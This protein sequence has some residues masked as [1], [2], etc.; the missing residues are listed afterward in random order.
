MNFQQLKYAVE[1]EKTESISK[2]A[3]KL[4]MGQPNLS[5]SIKELESEIGITLFT[6]SPK[7][8]SATVE[9]KEFLRYA[10]SIV[11]QVEE[12]QNTYV[13]QEKKWKSFTVAS[14]RATYVSL[15]FTNFVNRMIGTKD[16]HVQYRET[17]A[18][19]LINLV[20][21]GEANVGILRYNVM[22]EEYYLEQLMENNL[23]YEELMTFQM[24]VMVDKAHPLSAREKLNY[25]ELDNY[26]EIRHGDYYQLQNLDEFDFHKSL[27]NI[28]YVYDRASQFDIL[29]CVKGSYMFVSPMPQRFLI[30]SGFQCIAC[31][32]A[33]VHR[34]VLIFQREKKPSAYMPVFKE[35][36]KAVIHE[37][38]EEEPY[39]RS[40]DSIH[41]LYHAK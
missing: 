39:K 7:G 20:A 15:G 19:T 11:A 36:L 25:E 22:H 8:V 24:R 41:K 18:Y 14:V 10:R 28:I 33:S 2:A 1:V 38:E 34:D 29:R 12:L 26:I 27:G 4:F 6:R 32:N 5:K 3:K 21:S 9:G 37:I 23:D 13:N 40:K 31:E 16:L 35:S 17:N 30:K